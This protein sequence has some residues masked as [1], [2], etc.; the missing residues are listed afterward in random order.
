MPDQDPVAYL[1][2]TSWEGKKQQFTDYLAAR[3][4]ERNRFSALQWL[5]EK[6]FGGATLLQT[7]R[8][9]LELLGRPY[10][11]AAV[12]QSFADMVNPD[13]LEPWTLWYL[14]VA[15]VMLV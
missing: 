1:D 7:R 11:E 15:R 3:G 8:A 4:L 5:L 13:A 12:L 10:D 9:E 2:V 6:T 14:R